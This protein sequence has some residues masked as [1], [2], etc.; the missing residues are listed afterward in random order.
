MAT[1]YQ[2][3]SM[4]LLPGTSTC[5]QQLRNKRYYRLCQQF[6]SVSGQKH[7][8]VVT[9]IQD[10]TADRPNAEGEPHLERSQVDIDKTIKTRIP[11]TSLC[12]NFAPNLS[13]IPLL[14]LVTRLPPVVVRAFTSIGRTV[15]VIVAAFVDLQQQPFAASSIVV[16]VFDGRT[17][18]C[19]GS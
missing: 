1:R 5:N 6:L 3:L 14:W 4:Y 8:F 10:R 19:I 18:G 12:S 17:D 9:R 7:E 15:E 11:P 13:A 16:V 2:F